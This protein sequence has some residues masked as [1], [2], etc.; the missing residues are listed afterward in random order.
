MVL[1]ELVELHQ[2]LG[3]E[4]PI[5]SDHQ[6]ELGKKSAGHCLLHISLESL[7]ENV[8]VF[9]RGVAGG[10]EEQ[11]GSVVSVLDIF[12]ARDGDHVVH[13]DLVK[14]LM[15]LPH[16]QHFELATHCPVIEHTYSIS[17][18]SESTHQILLEGLADS[19][20]LVTNAREESFVDLGKR[21]QGSFDLVSLHDGVAVV[22]P[23]DNH[24]DLLLEKERLHGLQ[25]PEHHEDGDA[26]GILEEQGIVVATD[27]D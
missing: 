24:V 18:D 23:V 14:E 10:G 9:V 25:H 13:V 12:S 2:E 15:L 20:V 6:V 26:G 16:G 1:I 4:R 11:Q 3:L 19:Q 21:D 27:Q 7:E 8:E 22:V 5:A 17:G